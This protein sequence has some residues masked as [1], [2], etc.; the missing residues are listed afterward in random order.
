MA[1]YLDTSAM[2]R[3]VVAEPE[4][5]ALGRWLRSADGP[6]VTSDLTRTELVRAVRRH[7]GDHRAAARTV[8]ASFVTVSL[9]AS[10]FDSAGDLGP[11]R[12]RG[13]DAVHLAAAL[14]LGDQ[15]RGMVC[16]DL[17]LVEAAAAVGVPVIAPA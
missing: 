17:R 2:V 6:F 4:S 8:L 5:A 1:Y 15:L 14:R 13:L 3:L 12:L 11:D 9:P 10:L 7:R 16:Y